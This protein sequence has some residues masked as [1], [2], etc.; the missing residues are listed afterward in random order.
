MRVPTTPVPRCL[1]ATA[2]AGRIAAGALADCD[3]DG[4][5]SEKAL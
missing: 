5:S 1:S 4:L 2:V 3:K